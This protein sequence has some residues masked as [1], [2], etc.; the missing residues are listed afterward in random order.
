M[1]RERSVI[2]Q[3]KQNRS[4]K[5]RISAVRIKQPVKM[6]SLKSLDNLPFSTQNHPYTFQLLSCPSQNQ[7]RLIEVF[8]GRAA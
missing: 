3:T 4:K 6:P 5:W 8:A 1:G 7:N 2:L